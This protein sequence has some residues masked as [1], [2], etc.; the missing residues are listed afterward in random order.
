MTDLVPDDNQASQCSGSRQTGRW[1]GP[2]LACLLAVV[3]KTQ[4]DI[5]GPAL[6]TACI[7]VLMAVWWITEAIPLAATAMLP[8]ALFP[9]L[10]VGE[11]LA[12]APQIDESVTWDLDNPRYGEPLANSLNSDNQRADTG[13]LIELANQH[14]VVKSSQG[15]VAVPIRFIRAKKPASLFEVTSRSYASKFVFLMMGGFLLGMAI[16]RWNLHKRIALVTILA[17]GTAPVRLIAGFMVTTAML[18]MWISNTATTVVMLPIALS[19]ITLM[20]EKNPQ[21]DSYRLSN[22]AAC[23][24]LCIAYSASVG[25]LGTF[26]G[27]PTNLL[28]RDILEQNGIE[29]SFGQWMAFGLPSAIIF[30]II[31]WLLMTKVVFKVDLPKLEGGKLLI[32]EE[33]RKLGPM[34]SPEKT[35]AVLFGITAMLWVTRSFIT[36]WEWLQEFYPNIIYVDDTVIAMTA[37]LLLFVIP[38]LGYSGQT[39]MDWKTANRLPWGVL[40]LFGG[41]L[42][43]ASAVKSTG[44]GAIICDAVTPSGATAILVIMFVVTTA[45]IFMTEVTSNTATAALIL[46][47]LVTL[48]GNLEIDS[49]ILLIPATLAA[50]CAFMLPV[51]TPPNAIVFAAGQTSIRQMARAGLVLNL[52]SIVLLP[53]LTYII[54]QFVFGF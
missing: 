4:T 38:A 19:L 26:L 33:L 8:L 9:I 41:G 24:L 48:A 53:L 35:I 31:I 14:G 21:I 49:R 40:L 29:I 27:T 52:V 10:G 39:L 54:G 17:L 51:A 28:L 12:V 6:A 32:Q 47:L 16:E 34:S 1:L 46:P 13:Q 36:K 22:F 44:L 3:L 37:A 45:M 30:L 18:S 42:A 50:S 15:Q 20:R 7:V 43:L 11:K 5:P 25:G 23:L 2:V